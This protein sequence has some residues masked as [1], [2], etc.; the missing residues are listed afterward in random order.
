M[1][2]TR[3]RVT[4]NFTAA[5]LAALEPHREAMRKRLGREKLSLAAFIHASLSEHY[6][7][8]WSV[9][10]HGSADRLTPKKRKAKKTGR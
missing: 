5:E 10:E 8:G 1:P 6:R 7:L 9:P 4:S 3:E 2:T